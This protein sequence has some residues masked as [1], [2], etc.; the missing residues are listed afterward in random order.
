MKSSFQRCEEARSGQ[1]SGW[2]RRTGLKPGRRNHVLLR[3]LYIAGLRVSEI[4]DLKWPDLQPRTD[5]GQVTV[6]GKGGKTRTVL[7]PSTIWREM[8][9]FRRGAG[10]DTAVFASR[11]RGGHLHPTTIERIVLKAAQR[12]GVEGKVSPHWLRQSRDARARARR[13]VPPGAGGSWSLVGGHHGPLSARQAERF[14]CA[15]PRDLSNS[16]PV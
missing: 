14:E 3:L 13:A 6:F 15:L 8:L 7:L 16:W 2:L 1:R 4:A 12:A 9:R 10:L 11:S 5:G